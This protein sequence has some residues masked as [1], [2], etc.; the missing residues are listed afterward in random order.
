M[1]KSIQYLFIVFL[2]G[3]FYKSL[4]QSDFPVSKYSTA[5]NVHYWKNNSFLKSKGYWQQDVHYIIRAYI[6]EETDIVHG[7]Q[8]LH[9]TNNSNDT[10]PFVFFRLTQNAFQPGS[11][12]DEVYK[13]N[14]TKVDYGKYEVQLLGTTIDFIANANDTSK[15]LKTELDNTI[16]KVYLDKPLLPSQ[17]FSFSIRFKTYFDSKGSGRRRMKLFNSWGFKHYDGVHWYPRISVYDRKFGWTTDQ[18]LGKEFYGDFGTFD[19]ELNFASNFVLDAT[20]FLLNKQ[21]V[22]PAELRQKLDIKNFAQKPWNSPPSVIIPYNKNERKVWKFHA[23]NVHDF[24]FTADPTYRIG[25]ARYKDAEVIALCMEPH[26]SGWQ[27]AADFTV[28]VLDVF[29]K[30]FGEYVYNKMIVADAYD[31]MEYPMLTLDGGKDPDYRSL[32][33]HEVGHNW[34][35]GMIGNNE[36]YRAMLDEGFTQFLTAWAMD[37]IDGT[38][39]VTEPYKYA[40]QR[41]YKEIRNNKFTRC[42]NP[43]LLVA[44]KKEDVTINTHSDQFNTAL[45]HGGGYRLV[46]YKTATMLYNLQYVLG[47]SLFSECIKYYFNSWKIAHPYIEDMREAFIQKSKVD[48]NWF[49]DQWIETDKTIDYS[50]GKPKLI[51]KN[52]GTYSYEIKFKRKGTMQMPIDFLVFGNAGKTKSFHIPNQWFVKQTNAQVLSKWTGWDLLNKT[53]TAKVEVPFKINKIAIDTSARLADTYRLDNQTKCPVKYSF[54]HQLKTPPDF[55]HYRVYYRPELWYNGIDGL[56]AGLHINGN[57]TE[58]IH[59]FGATVWYNT[60]VAEQAALPRVLNIEPVSFN[61]FYR[62]PLHIKSG[63]DF[64]LNAA[65]LDGLQLF[66]GGIKKGNENEDNYLYFYIKSMNRFSADYILDKRLWQTAEMNNSVNVFLS[67][68]IRNESVNYWLSLHARTGIT[69]SSYSF[70]ALQAKQTVNLGLL[71]LRTRYFA[72]IGSNNTPVESMLYLSGASPEQMYDN[73]FLRSAGFFPQNWSI[74]GETSNHLHYGGGLN[75]RGYAGYISPTT[76]FDENGQVVIFRANSGAAINTEF[77]F[78]KLTS[79]V[80]YPLRRNI[81]IDPY[82]FADIGTIAVSANNIDYLFTRADAGLGIAATVFKWGMLEKT[83]PLTIRFDMPLYLSNAPYAEQ[84]NIMFR[85]QLGI[86]KAF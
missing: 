43:Y 32:I 83:S 39:P 59:Q 81:F 49:F 12:M 36:T 25:E 38:I 35:F 29:S 40:Y 23:E 14:K 27:N 17:T 13:A 61:A 24:A 9:Y 73:K 45:G 46:Y 52:N 74:Y 65:R 58:K 69:P 63:S 18:H 19:V 5:E 4:A 22:L 6:D 30:D 31:G 42:Y 37:K 79:K 16:L 11:Y 64:Y 3:L 44:Q 26:C 8:V 28:K 56:K 55:S 75:L 47:D 15:I 84:N 86:E 82:L 1:K 71:E 60:G 53:Y 33:A 77:S 70:L 78:S 50:V 34:F 72:R 51:S 67:K 62:T 21:Q 41:K 68:T 2:L 54:D 10:L 7:N 57:Y 20:G 80:K 76:L 85:W 66:E 48:L